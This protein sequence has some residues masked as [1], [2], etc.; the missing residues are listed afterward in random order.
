MVISENELENQL[1]EAGNKLENPPTS[2]DDLILLLNQVES[3]LSKVEQSPSQNMRNALSPS[4]KALVADQLF[5][6][7]DD[8]VKVAVASCISEITRITAPDAP[9]DDDQMKEIFQLIV[10][11]FENISDMSSRSFAKRTAILE[12]VAKVRS[13]VVMLDLELD[14][15]LVEMFQHFLKSIRDDHPKNL[16]QAMETIMALVLEESEDISLDLLSPILSTMKKNSEDVLPAAQKLGEK[17]LRSASD[18]VKECLLQAVKSSSISLD[19]FNELVTALCKESG[20]DEQNGT[21]SATENVVDEKTDVE[22]GAIENLDPGSDKSL[23]PI[24]NGAAQTGEA[25]SLAES[26][27]PKRLESPESKTGAGPSELDHLTSEKVVDVETKVHDKTD[28]EADSTEKVDA[29]PDKSTKSNNQGKKTAVSI[30]ITGPSHGP[31]EDVEKEAKRSLD[32]KRESKDLPSSGQ[33]TENEKESDLLLPPEAGEDESASIV[34]PSSGNLPENNHTKKAEH[35]ETREA[36]PS[37]ED[38]S[39]KVPQETSDS[40]MKTLKGPV[41]ITPTNSSNDDDK[42]IPS[43]TSKRETRVKKGVQDKMKDNVNKEAA[44]STE[45]GAAKSSK[46]TSDSAAKTQQGPVTKANSSTSIEDGSQILSDTSKRE[47]HAK[48]D[49]DAKK[50][51]APSTEVSSP[52]KTE[53]TSDAEVKA[54]KGSVKKASR[55]KGSR[56]RKISS[57]SRKGGAIKKNE[58]ATGF[59]EDDSA[60]LSEEDTGIDGHTQKGSVNKE[61]A[62]SPI[63]HDDSK[64]GSGDISDKEAKSLKGSGKKLDDNGDGSNPLEDKSRQSRGDVLSEKDE[65][66]ASEAEEN[67]EV[68]SSPKPSVKSA[69]EKQHPEKTPKTNFKRKRSASADK[70]SSKDNNLVG[71]KIKVWWPL[72]KTYYDGIIASY[73]SK[74]KRHR[75][76]YADGEVE[77]LNLATEKWEFIT[78]DSEAEEEETA[79]EPNPESSSELPLKKKFKATSGSSCKA[80]KTGGGGASSSKAKG[81]KSADVSKAESG[82]S[83]ACTKSIADDVDKG[84]DCITPKSGS[85][86]KKDDS[87]KQKSSSGKSKAVETTTPNKA[88]SNTTKG[89]KSATKGGSKAN[90]SDHASESSDDLPPPKAVKLQSQGGSSKAKASVTKSGKKRPRAD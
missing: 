4:L 46:E 35:A 21:P 54:T 10:S 66:T 64:T 70:T 19:D 50:K 44:P 6:H 16:V 23:K 80:K 18:K 30:K 36:A 72:D 48:Q 12:T 14:S 73:D 42:R 28:P 68:V 78:E 52:K 83:K 33:V 76:K 63:M 67:M 38:S 43:G 37:T 75:V 77:V 27:S 58:E 29:G 45:D 61:P 22:A 26:G 41:K 7:S 17:V 24:V 90:K 89:N 20:P 9:Y 51:G 53:E 57:A 62:E 34:S 8:D 88:S 32:D 55:R 11:S 25:D 5:K 81:S 13:C 84:K 2:I 74:K 49:T 1:R 59:A 87:E 71:S 56:S 3:Y 82:K 85:K 79:D 31:K 60:N 40:E 86:S 39:A 47:S 65:E 69:R 15:L